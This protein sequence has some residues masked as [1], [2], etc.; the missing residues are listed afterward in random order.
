M[1]TKSLTFKDPHDRRAWQPHGVDTWYLGPA[2]D[3]YRL[4]RFRDPATGGNAD[5]GTFRPYPAHCRMPT[6]SES[7]RIVVTSADL[8]GILKKEQPES[9]EERHKHVSILKQLTDIL[10]KNICTTAARTEVEQRTLYICQPNISGH[11]RNNKTHRSAL[12]QRQQTISTIFG[13]ASPKTSM[14][15]SQTKKQRR[16][17]KYPT[18]HST[19]SYANKQ[20]RTQK[21]KQLNNNDA[22]VP[23]VR[24][25]P[26]R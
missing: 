10:E 19:N 13:G 7:D 26:S 21:H 23:R 6:I 12:C 1:G 14:H 18:K 2:M 22:Y 5:A 4:M 16:R 25:G 8:V 20:Q 11:T 17:T 24:D 3:H 9:V 15:K